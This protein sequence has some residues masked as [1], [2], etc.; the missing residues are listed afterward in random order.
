MA[1]FS[2][3]RRGSSQTAANNQA[4]QASTETLQTKPEIKP[5][6]VSFDL[7]K[8]ETYTQTEYIDPINVKKINQKTNHRTRD[9]N[10]Y[11]CTK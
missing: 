7:T 4:A 1:Q 9:E 3:R 8:K 11:K 5:S 2:L 10:Y 6:V